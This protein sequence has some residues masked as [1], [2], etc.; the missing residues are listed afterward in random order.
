MVNAFGISEHMSLTLSE[1]PYFLQR[2]SRMLKSYLKPHILT[3]LMFLCIII[4]AKELIATIPER[5]FQVERIGVFISNL[6]EEL[7]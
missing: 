4:Q 2:L 3:L 7:I 6:R 5:I 1:A